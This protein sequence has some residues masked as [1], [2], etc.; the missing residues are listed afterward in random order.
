[1]TYV[2]GFVMAVPKSNK[3]QIHRACPHRG[4]GVHRAGPPVFSNAGPTTCPT[5]RSRISASAV[6]ANGDETVVFS[7]IE[8]PDKAT[9][10]A[11][12]KN[13][14]ERP[15]DEPESNPMPF[16]AKRMIF[17]GFA[18]V[19]ELDWRSGRLR[20]SERRNRI[21]HPRGRR[22]LASS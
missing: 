10:D 9:R 2:D 12:M 17:G 6:Q 7:W 5:A 11:G 19:V 3:Q 16:D 21:T 1:M 22:D 8:W 4:C 14:D 18:P 20:G 15:S 13:D